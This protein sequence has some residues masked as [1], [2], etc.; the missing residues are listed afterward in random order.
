MSTK[1]RAKQ[2]LNKFSGRL[3]PQ[4]LADGMN[5]ASENANRLAADARLLFDNARYASAMALAILAIEES[6]KLGVLRGIAVAADDA[7]LRSAWSDYRTHTRKNVAWTL[8]HE[9]Q[10]GARRFGD[11]AKMF[12]EDAEHPQILDNVK[13]VA[14]YTDCLGDCH[15][16]KPDSAITR[17]LAEYMVVAAKGMAKQEQV[18]AEEMELWIGY[19]KPAWN[20]A[21]ARLVALCDWD[22]EMRARGLS[23]GEVTMERFIREG[24]PEPAKPQSKT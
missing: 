13:Q 1:K 16:S 3:T 19:L 11:F 6:G 17:E 18:T 23:K 12:E 7:A 5:A 14:F 20:E 8:L 24:F 4:Q 15:W 21:G 2:G 9:L 22:K 10:S